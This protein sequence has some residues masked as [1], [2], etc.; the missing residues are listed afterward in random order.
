MTRYEWE[1]ELKKYIAALPKTEQ[2]KIFDYYGEIFEDKIEA[3]MQEEQIIREFGNPYDVASRI[4]SDFKIEKEKTEEPDLSD[5]KEETEKEINE[6]PTVNA[7][8]KKETSAFSRFILAAVLFI[9]VGL[10]ALAVLAGLAFCGVALLVSAVALILG[11]IFDFFYFVAMLGMYGYSGAYLAHLG[12]GLMI[13][14]TGFL[15]SPLFLF[16]TKKLFMLCGKIFIKT[17]NYI[18]N[19]RKVN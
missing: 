5:K 6:T 16:L 19:K 18:S 14:A 3:G 1:R 9:F 4:L 11:G 8:E 15:L 12:I 2:A 7:P 10:P 13:T 17:G